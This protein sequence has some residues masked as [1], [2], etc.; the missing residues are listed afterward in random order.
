MQNSKPVVDSRRFDAGGGE[1]YGDLRQGSA[2]VLKD[3]EQSGNCGRTSEVYGVILKS[4][5][6]SLSVDFDATKRKIRRRQAIKWL[7]AILIPTFIVKWNLI[8]TIG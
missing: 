6:N 2:R 1:G 4:D 5:Q 3:V 8:D 7:I